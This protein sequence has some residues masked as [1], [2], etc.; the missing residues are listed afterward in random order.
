MVKYASAPN[1]L[2]RGRGVTFTSRIVDGG[3]SGGSILAVTPP[4]NP[5]ALEFMGRAASPSITVSRGVSRAAAMDT[6]A[7]DE[8]VMDTVT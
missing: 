6:Y 7:G 4:V 1:F 8:G 2:G 3:P 5:K